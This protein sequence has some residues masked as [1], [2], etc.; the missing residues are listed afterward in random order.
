MTHSALARWHAVGTSDCLQG[1]LG[2]TACGCT[3]ALGEW[4]GSTPCR[5]LPGDSASTHRSQSHCYTGL[6]SANMC[7]WPAWFVPSTHVTNQVSCPYTCTCVL[8]D[9]VLSAH[10][11]EWALTERPQYSIP[12]VDVVSLSWGRGNPYLIV[13][14]YRVGEYLS[15]YSFT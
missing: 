11:L 10:Y 9:V 8:L 5:G 12:C 3:P 6:S 7:L 14:C 13:H 15:M 2:R 4:C 1:P